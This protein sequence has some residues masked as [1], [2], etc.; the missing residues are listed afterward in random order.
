MIPLQK[1]QKDPKLG[2]KLLDEDINQVFSNLDDLI[3]LHSDILNELTQAQEMYPTK[4]VGEIF[5]K[6]VSTS[7]Y[8]QK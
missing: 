7:E 5:I 1:L 6:K 2:V 3:T 4:S 8:T